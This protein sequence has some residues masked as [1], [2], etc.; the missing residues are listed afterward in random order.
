MKGAGA[1]GAD[2]GA[3]VL[4]RYQNGTLTNQPLWDPVTGEF[5]HG[6]I[7]AGVNDI[8][9]SSLFDVHKRLNVN[10][11]G[12]PFPAGYAS[13]AVAQ[14]SSSTGPVGSWN[15][16]E[17]SGTSVSDASGNGNT[18]TLLNGPIWTSGVKGTALS[19]DGVDDYVDMGS[20]PPLNITGPAI[21]VQAWAKASSPGNY[22]YIISK[23]DGLYMGYGL[24]TGSSGTLRFYIGNGSG[25]ITTPDVT[26]PWDNRWHHIAG[27]YDGSKLNLYIDGVARASVAA[28]GSIADSSARSLNIGGFSEGGFLFKGVV[29]DVQ[30]YN[31]ALSAT[32]IQQ[33]YSAIPVPSSPINLIV[34]K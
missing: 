7:V 30:I 19:F 9:G 5:P 27:T 8:A 11:N 23:T 24:Y 21:T 31:R 28:T 16:D 1:G 25:L 3:N 17:G 4:Y 12:C 18:G 22:K 32:E 6:A 29:D 2:I 26:S 33:L 10:T 34:T 15:F 13:S 14:T 20:P